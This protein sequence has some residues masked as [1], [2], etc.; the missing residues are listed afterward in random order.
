MAALCHCTRL[1]M[2]TRKVAALYDA[3]L[4]P[5]GIN[6]TQYALLRNIARRQPV[7]LTGLAR[8]LELDRSTMGR[9][10]RVLEKLRLA[11][12]RRGED[13]R[14]SVVLLTP[15][16]TALLDE[17]GP[18]WERCQDDIARRIGPE[19]LKA[20]NEISQIF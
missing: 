9:N 20:L 15:A 7:S 8:A 13:Q 5:L 2:T 3:A 14:E 4:E 11:E 19:R 10:I 6:I 16:G 12:T 18:L 1:R 17:A